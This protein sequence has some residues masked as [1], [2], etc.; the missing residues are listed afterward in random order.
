MKLTEI[1]EKVYALAG[2]N[3]TSE[4]KKL[5]LALKHLDFRRKASWQKALNLLDQEFQ[6]WLK[7]PPAP[8]AELFREVDAALAQPGLDLQA[9]L[10]AIAFGLEAL[11]QEHIN[12]AEHLKTLLKA[13]SETPTAKK[14]RRTQH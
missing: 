1:K 14:R 3:S 2:V 6:A 11:A 4:L 10:E 5:H 13:D 7:Q 9:E 8:Y 12:E